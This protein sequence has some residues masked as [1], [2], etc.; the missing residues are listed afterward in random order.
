MPCTNLTIYYKLLDTEISN[1]GCGI[2]LSGRMGDEG[3]FNSTMF[4]KDLAGAELCVCTKA[5]CPAV[6]SA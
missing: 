2:Q 6:H 4:G 5:V 3:E 1:F